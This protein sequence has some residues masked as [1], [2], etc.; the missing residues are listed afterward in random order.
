MASSGQAS[1]SLG[2]DDLGTLHRALYPAR[3]SY[4]SLGL[5]IGVKIGEIKSIESES[6]DNGER[7]LGVLSV[8]LKKAEPLTWN[9]TDSALR[10]DCVG[11]G[12]TA[13]GIRQKYGHLF[14][15]DPSSVA[16][17][18]QETKEEK[19]KKKRRKKGK[20]RPIY[21]ERSDRD[22]GGEVGGRAGGKKSTSQSSE[23]SSSSNSEEEVIVKQKK[24]RKKAK[25]PS[26]SVGVMP[27]KKIGTKRKRE[28]HIKVASEESDREYERELPKSNKAKK[29]IKAK[30]KSARD[31]ISSDDL[32]YQYTSQRS[33]RYKRKPQVFES[34]NDSSA[35]SSEE[36]IL[37][38]TDTRRK[39][40]KAKPS[41][42]YAEQSKSIQSKEWQAKQGGKEQV[43]PKGR[44]RAHLDREVGKMSHRK[45]KEVKSESE[46]EED[47]ASTSDEGESSKPKQKTIST[48]L[49]SGEITEERVIKRKTT[50]GKG[51]KRVLEHAEEYE[52]SEDTNR[53][54][55]Q[56]EGKRK[57]KDRVK[58][59]EVKEARKVT[60]SSS[61][62]TDDSSPECDV[63][64]IVSESE[65][66]KL[67]KVFKC[68]YGKLCYAIKDPNATAVQ[69]QAK[70]LLSRSK[71]KNVLISPESQ[72]VKAIAIVHALYQKIK[73]CPEKLF[74]VSEVCLH[75]ESLQEVG[76]E[77][78]I[79]IGK[80]FIPGILGGN[81]YTISYT[82][83]GKVCPDRP[84]SVFTPPEIL[85][86][87]E[88]DTGKDK[89]F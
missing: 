1:S 30:K 71:L 54:K 72:Q 70:R 37:S 83:S 21:Q 29:K 87:A 46:S 50:G 22:S 69:L 16:Q 43:P 53:S 51:M 26:G 28:R 88:S 39:Q 57:K 6:T 76:T 62:E 32:D 79:E 61:S 3:N 4:K 17:T 42:K 40:G 59:G 33:K 8:R 10:L 45:Q 80:W 64:R 36:E 44:D 89:W 2:D 67:V 60:S 9:D 48:P 27:R 25:G 84:A 15:P 19:M 38:H 13:D 47:L 23:E 35:T 73:S 66:K 52:V 85:P 86:T 31:E 12:K 75:N 74:T 82:F 11:E 58:K 55:H 78:S 77:M 56:N 34:D 5:Q 18:H 41:A 65:N 68:N 14:S 24:V 7:L 20:G 81:Y 49:P 63:G